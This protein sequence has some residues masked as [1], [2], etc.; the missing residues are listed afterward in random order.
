MGRFLLSFTAIP[1]WALSPL[2]VIAAESTNWL[3]ESPVSMMDWGTQKAA[4]SVQDAADSLNYLTKARSDQDDRFENDASIPEEVKK[5]TLANRERLHFSPRTYG[6]EYG[7]G[8]AEYDARRDRVVLGAFV[9]PYRNL[10][11]INA[12]SCIGIVEDLRETLGVRSKLDVAAADAQEL[13]SRWFSHS[14]Y[15][16]APKL[17]KDLAEHTTVLI[18]LDWNTITDAEV[19]CEQLLPGGEVSVVKTKP[20]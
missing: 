11:K 12:E 18:Y 1:L 17:A 20:K 2:N 4:R 3:M 10:G 15:Q 5:K 19:K 7:P 6:Y 9:K 14:G 16:L 8:F 13:V